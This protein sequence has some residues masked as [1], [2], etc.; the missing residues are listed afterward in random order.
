MLLPVQR[1]PAV[2]VT[3]GGR[4]IGRAI[5]LRFAREGA[6]VAVAA[7]T[8]AEIERVAREV[9]EAGGEG[10][11]VEMDVTDLDSVERGIAQVLE[12]SGG[13]LDVLVNNAGVFAIR[14]FPELSP[15]TWYRTIATNLT[16]PF[17]VTLLALRGLEKSSRAHVFNISSIAGKQAFPGNAAYCA[18]K[19]GLRGL[20]DALRLDLESRRIR[21]STVYPSATDTTIFDDVPGDWDRANMHRPEEVA[22]LV[23]RAYR[24]PSDADV[25]D[26]ELPPRGPLR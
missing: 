8:R 24:S 14:P 10:L 16:G 3:G 17:H 13:L 23:W 4:G 20:S 26:L 18:S 11:A 19:Y 5:A 6:F 22:E 15:A 12:A 2:L 21:V 7:R 1:T 9:R 25:A